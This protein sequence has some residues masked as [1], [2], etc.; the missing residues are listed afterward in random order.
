VNN[1]EMD[2][3]AIGWFDMSW[4]DLAQDRGECGDNFRVQQNAGK[5]LN[6]FTSSGISRE[7]QTHEPSESVSSN[8]SQLGDRQ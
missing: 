4:I 1:N 2:I 3:R 7:S 5:L 6:Q 8:G